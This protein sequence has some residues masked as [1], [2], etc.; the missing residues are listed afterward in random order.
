MRPGHVHRLDRSERPPPPDLGGRR[1][2]RRRGDGRA[3]ARGSTSRC[4][5]TAAAGSSTTAGGSR[6]TR[7]RS[8]PRQSRGRDRAHDAARRRQVRRQRLQGLRR[9]AR[10]R[11]L[12][13]ERPVDAARARDRP[14]RQALRDGV[15]AT[16]ASRPARSRS[17][18]H[19][20]RGRTG[21]TV[22]FWP[23]PTIFDEVEF[24]AQTVT[25]R[26]QMMA[27]LNKGLEIRFADERQADEQQVDLQVQRRHRRL[28]EAPERVQGVALPQGRAPSSSPRTTRRSRSRC[29]GTPATTRAST[30]SPTA[31]R[32]PRAGCTRRASRRPSPT[33]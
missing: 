28:R 22:T 31:S 32:P 18:G 24:R 15:H 14:R 12:G 10:R 8:D 26:L 2:L 25:E 27:F 4:W 29:S 21:T 19:A 7:T 17:T 23:D 1:Q 9:P 5:P 16:A 30:P 6:S 20:P 13:R 11:R 3:T 33:W